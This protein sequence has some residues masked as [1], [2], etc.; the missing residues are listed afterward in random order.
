MKKAIK[1][2][3]GWRMFIFRKAGRDLYR[4]EK[5]PEGY[6]VIAVGRDVFYSE[7]EG[8]ARKVA[9]KMVPKMYEVDEVSPKKRKDIQ[10][11]IRYIREAT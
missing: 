10:V 1:F 8:S 5:W 7:D 4:D 3:V 9:M 6:H 2:I 11:G